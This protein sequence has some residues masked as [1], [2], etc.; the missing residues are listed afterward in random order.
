MEI[1][2]NDKVEAQEL[3]GLVHR[4]VA[5]H[6]QGMKKMEVWMQTI[7]AGAAT[8]IHKHDCEEVVIVLSGSGT[9]TVHG[10]TVEFGPNT[11]LTFE[12]DV[13]HQI[14]NTSDEEMKLV[15]TLAMAPVRVTTPEGE[16]IPLPW[17]APDA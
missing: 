2:D 8:P 6:A 14:V 13:V 9:C 10:R 5:G 17:D 16:R 12:P 11:T 15:A 3:P 4:T 1:V 7:A